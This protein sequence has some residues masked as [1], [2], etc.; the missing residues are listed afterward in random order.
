MRNVLV[1][2]LPGIYVERDKEAARLS[3]T[4]ARRVTKWRPKGKSKPWRRRKAIEA[5]RLK[6]LLEDGNGS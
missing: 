2:I 3:K 1:E 6:A 4:T 5:A